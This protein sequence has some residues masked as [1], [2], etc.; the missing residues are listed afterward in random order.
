MDASL[1]IIPKLW[2]SSLNYFVPES[3]L[4]VEH[5]FT[6]EK[7]ALPAAALKVLQRV[8]STKA[9]YFDL[10]TAEAMAASAITEFKQSEFNALDFLSS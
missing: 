2:G 9:Q 4:K 8:K 10:K 1:G 3:L 6:E 7:L 5:I